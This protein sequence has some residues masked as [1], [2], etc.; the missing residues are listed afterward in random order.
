MP[1]NRRQFLKASGAAICV[2]ALSRSG[3]AKAN[4]VQRLPIPPLIESRRGRP[5]FL[6]MQAVNWSFCNGNSGAVWGFNGQYLGPTIRVNNG[7]N[8]KL[9]CSNR[10][11]ETIGLTVSGLQTP[12]A[13]INNPAHIIKP[14][15]S[16]SPV[17][18]IRQ[19][20]ST[21]W[22]HARTPKNSARQLYNGLAGMWIV[23]DADSNR[24]NLPNYYGVDDFPVI[25][26]DKHFSFA[27]VPEY[28]PPYEEGFLGDTLLTNGVH[29]PV[30][31]TGKSWIRLRLL[32]ASN[33][34]RY[35]LSLSNH[36]PMY[37]VAADRGLLVAPIMLNE[38]Y[39]A[40]GERKEILIDM[41]QTDEVALMTGV[42]RKLADRVRDFFESPNVLKATNV[43]TL[44][45]TGL[46]QAVPS[47]L[48]ERF[49][50]NDEVNY[51]AR[52]SR[53]L[54]LKADGTINGERWRADRIDIR[55]AINSQER[56]LVTAD[57]PQA[58]HIQG[59]EFRVVSAGNTVP[60]IE[61]SGWKDTVWIDSQVELLVRF[62]QPSSDYFPFL[63]QSRNLEF[64]D[65]GAAGQLIV[66]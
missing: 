63:Y 59:A 47:R 46:L 16:W 32:N 30:L 15:A 65:R 28:K 6:S 64:A 38:F 41:S 5:I 11:F 66:S 48:P 19:A 36:Q 13:I 56:W 54:D 39:L 29:E 31:E 35:L 40:P 42:R 10:L 8:V 18:P 55:A 51:T 24:Q 7:D 33:S 23:D 57:L 34:R 60:R 26:Q 9:S 50:V 44:K 43:L 3:Y 25:L 21:C 12:G 17:L 1:L 14:D 58:F 2:G 20:A 62:R 37:L 27:G 4:A 61:D 45:S 22:Y 53:Q 52:Q 49:I